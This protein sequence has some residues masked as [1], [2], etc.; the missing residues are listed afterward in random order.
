MHQA[1][2]ENVEN[3]TLHRLFD[4]FRAVLQKAR[5]EAG[6]QKPEDP[7]YVY[8]CH[9]AIVQALEKGDVKKMQT[10]LKRH[11]ATVVDLVKRLERTPPK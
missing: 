5:E 10:A 3:E 6:V 8:R 1:L 7:V 9:A 11:Y 4:I 2:W